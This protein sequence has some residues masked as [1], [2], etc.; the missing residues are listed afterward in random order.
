MNYVIENEKLK[1]QISDY[2]AELVSVYSKEQN[3]ECLWQP[4]VR[5]WDR[6]APVLFPVCGRFFNGQY[7]YRSN[8]YQMDCH[9]FG[10]TSNFT[11]V[12]SEPTTITFELTDNE[13]THKTYP[14]SFVFQV[15]YTLEK[16]TVKTDMYVKNTGNDKMYFSVGGHPGFKVPMSDGEEFEDYYVDFGEKCSPEIIHHFHSGNDFEPY[17]LAD[18]QTLPLTHPLFDEDGVFLRKTTGFAAIRSKKSDRA[19]EVKYH[20]FPNVGIWHWPFTD[21]NYVCIEPWRTLPCSNRKIPDLEKG[22]I[23]LLTLDP[24]CEYTNGFEF[25]II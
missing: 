12:S 11:V 14:F 18:G 17:P 2:G 5:Y 15:K 19:I 10:W 21:A 4:D 6:Q 13:E 22:E 9:G 3:R 25:K 24:E 20:N 1:V 23:N 16:S 7:V 8:T